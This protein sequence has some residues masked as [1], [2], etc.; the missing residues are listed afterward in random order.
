[1]T[2]FPPDSDRVIAKLMLRQATSLVK[3]LVYCD[4]IA[5]VHTIGMVHGE[6]DTGTTGGYANYLI[7]ASW[8]KF[9]NDEQ[10]SG[11]RWN[12][13]SSGAVLAQELTHNFWRY[14]IGCR[15]SEDSFFGLGDWPYEDRCKID[16]R[17]LSEP[18]T[19]FGFDPIS[20]QIIRPSDAGDF[21]TYR[22]A[23]WVSDFTFKDVKGIL[24]GIFD[25]D[26]LD[27]GFVAATPTTVLEGET[28]LLSGIYEATS[29]RGRF[30]YSYVLP[31][32]MLTDVATGEPPTEVGA[33]HAHH[34]PLAEPDAHVRIL[35]TDGILLE[36]YQIDLIA[37]DNHGTA[38]A[39]YYFLAQ[40][41][42]P[43][44]AVAR[45][46]LIV[47]GELIDSI[48]P[49]ANAPDVEILDP[50]INETLGAEIT[51]RWR[52]TDADNDVML[53]SINYSPDGGTSWL[54]LVTEYPGDVENGVEKEITTLTLES[55]ET[56]PGSD[57]AYLRVIATDGFNT[58]VAEAGPFVVE[59]RTPI[60]TIQ[61]PTEDE[62]YD[63]AQPIT[64]RG[65]VYDAEQG[66]LDDA[67]LE[68]SING[69]VVGDGHRKTVLGLAPGTYTVELKAIDGADQS[70]TVEASLNLLPLSI[71]SA[72][73]L[74]MDGRCNDSAYVDTTPL[75]LSGYD[76][77]GNASVYFARRGD[78]LWVCLAALERVEDEVSEV[79][80]RIDPNGSRD[81]DAQADDYLF[82]LRED[83]SPLAFN[84]NGAGLLDQPSGIAFSAQ[85]AAT[86]TA[87]SAEFR[88]PATSLA[89]WGSSFGVAV[90]HAN[91]AGTYRWPHATE[92]AAPG[93]WAEVAAG[94]V[95]YIDGIFPNSVTVG[96]QGFVVE[97]EGVRFGEDAS[98]FWAGIA[99]STVIS[100]SSMLSVAVDST[101]LQNAGEVEL[102]VVNTTT[103][104]YASNPVNFVIYNVTPKI[105]K[106]SPVGSDVGAGAQK[107]TISGQDFVEGSVALWDGRPRP[108]H[109]INATTL[110]MDLSAA[111][112]SLEQA[113]GVTVLVPEPRRSASNTVAFVVGDPGSSSSSM[114]EVLFLPL[115]VK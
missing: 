30:F 60:A 3:S 78:D 104:Q 2:N 85:P 47:D 112:L 45:I 39:G 62:W 12:Q 84:G 8:V 73:F 111:D 34:G 64:L 114:N 100:N 1:M 103:S 86:D 81:A 87:W 26:D 83:G 97:V 6:S 37:P 71:E 44:S 102:R 88:I 58:S 11:R 23:R 41:P 29:E 24:G 14:H 27:D 90:E 99:Q 28:L 42:K 4:D 72:P 59:D 108:T 19:H 61:A 63:P 92:D 13:P 50:N 82:L 76:S 70:T 33:A 20:R 43:E 68:W 93:S 107:V 109:F 101:L 106:L 51:I 96:D 46:Q 7:N 65:L 36:E 89:L 79:G 9:E 110:E 16:D 53:F 18:T 113:L 115:V 56:L 10:N 55:P 57:A 80:L 105:D 48:A 94:P 21:M 15:D 38:E 75:P 40:L 49:S 5:E 52:A 22:R 69:Q 17:P 54:P 98:L 35:G 95:P 66:L 67:A 74:N 32:A 25:L 77:G 31:D 91:E